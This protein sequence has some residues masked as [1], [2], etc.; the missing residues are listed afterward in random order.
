MSIKKIV[1]ISFILILFIIT[2][3]GLINTV[4]IYQI[5]E[6]NLAKQSI[7]NLV[8]MQERMNELLKDTINLDSID[9]LDKYKEDFSKYE[10]EFEKIQD[11]FKEQDKNDLIDFF[12]TDIQKDEII[13][14][15]LALLFES[16]QEIEKAFDTIYS[17]QETKIEITNEF[18]NNYPVE[19]ELRK[20]LDHE[21]SERKNF[22]LA[23]LFGD[24]KYYS[25]E[26]LYQKRDK[27]TFDKWL[28][29]IALLK[30]SFD[31]SDTEKYLEIVGKVGNSV[32]KIKEIEDQEFDIRNK[33][34][35]IINLNKTYSSEMEAKIEKLSSDF[36]NIT[37]F[38]ILL[39]LIIVISFLA[40]LAYKVYR[41]VGLSVDEIETKIEDGLIEITNLNHEI[42]NTQKEVVFTM[43]AI[44]ESRSKET[45]NH[46]KRVAEY[47]KL[48]AFYYGLDEKEA[49]LLKQA[50]PMHDIGKV[51]IPD[52]ILN[53]PGRFDESERE[54]MNTHASLGYEM[55]KHSNRPLLKMAAIVANEHHEKWDGTGYPR[56]LSGED[57]HIYGRI[58]ALADVFDALG[59]DRVYKK[60]WDDEK[61]FNLFKEERAKHFDPKLVDIFFEH[62]DEFLKIR[63]TFKD[64]F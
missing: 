43:G 62:L 58:T 53:K 33:S 21:I 40:L 31:N 45:G 19:N 13:A 20:K 48:L 39:L 30:H 5:K 49:E 28:R 12:I 29:K 26:V 44:G 10:L 15:K 3:I 47:S 56:G 41:N 22:D 51:A 17:L 14:I 25:K 16:E 18:N 32:V 11:T 23:Q 54:I 64:K 50:S 38:S 8:S 59:S 9:K 55:L 61:I 46:V 57:I 34:F 37:Y 42:E 2:I 4:I 63:K 6:N 52:A 36:I 35:N 1:K 7:T 24:V 27:E 60:A